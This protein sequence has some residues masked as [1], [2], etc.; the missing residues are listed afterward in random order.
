MSAPT[1]AARAIRDPSFVAGVLAIA[2][3]AAIGLQAH[4]RGVTAPTLDGAY[5]LD[6]AHDIAAGDVLGL[7][8]TVHG[9]AFLF[10]PLYAY[11]IAP[12]VAVF[13]RAEMP[14]VI[15]Q[16]LLAGATAAL[17]AGAARRYAGQVA[18]WVAG[19]AVAFSA[20]LVHL[21]GKVAVSGLAAF[22]VAGVVWST[23]PDEA[24]EHARARGRGPFA[25]GAWIGLSLLAR[26]V[27][28]AALPFAAW[29]HARRS[30]RPGHVLALVLVP[31]AVCAGVSLARNLA[32]A[33]DPVVFTAAN[34]QNLHLG[35][36]P[37]ARRLMAMATDEFRFGPVV[38][39]E[40]AK[41]RVAYELRREP[42]RAEVSSWFADRALDDFR[43]A[44][45]AS[46]AWYGT[47]LRWFAGPAELA[48]SDEMAADRQRV[49]LS[50]LAFVPTWLLVAL[51]AG[52]VVAAARRDDL[53]L[54]P[55]AVVA[56]HVLACTLVYPLA[57]YRSPAVPALAVMAGVGVS[58]AVAAVRARRTAVLSGSLVVA[59]GVAVLGALPPQASA[60]PEARLADEAAAAFARGDDA[61]ADD[62]AQRSLARSPGDPQALAVRLMVAT[63]Q[64]RSEDARAHAVRL[65][66]LRPWDPD[67]RLDVAWND[68]RLGR[69]PDAL[70]EADAVVA[71]Y[72]W[73][74]KVRAA[75]AGMRAVAG[76]RAGALDDVEFA[77][78]RGVE[79]E[80]WVLQRLGSPDTR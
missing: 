12:L 24:D 52:S 75:R 26:P 77:R 55:G 36:N 25:T 23:A 44:P 53:L 54:G 56:A 9:E 41:Y 7:H 5:Y 11:V 78:Q 3:R 39:H 35:N 70:R 72:P 66:E 46:L 1:T 32:V 28:L 63:R 30:S 80:P 73:S 51:A 4:A 58:Q 50:A 64:G 60:F 27:L 45:G 42:S 47:K 21:D 20:V 57:H 59:A 69:T 79:V 76:D 40:D 8:G 49:P 14:V 62:L 38:M 67:A 34:G 18:A 10:N 15:L 31:V 22:L 65:T 33:G 68:L 61:A 29:A 37:S 13:G 71:I 48:S 17:A 16:A 19:L 2:V 43:A 6:W 74:A